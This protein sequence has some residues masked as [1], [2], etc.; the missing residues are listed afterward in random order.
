MRYFF[1]TEFIH[2]PWCITLISIGVVAEDGRE[3]YGVFDDAREH[4]MSRWVKE[5]V[6]P[7]MQPSRAPAFTAQGLSRIK[8][9]LLAFI[10]D[11]SAPEFW[12]YYGAHDWVVLT[13]ILGG[14]LEMPQGWPML[15]M[16]LRIEL[17]RTGKGDVRDDGRK[18]EHNSLADARWVRDAWAAH[19]RPTA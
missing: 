15:T 11:D 5:N 9:D 17:D 13:D 12:A 14:M 19:L 4:E 1:D 2:K 7:K 3:F 8:S 16:D 18:D 6:L 10:G